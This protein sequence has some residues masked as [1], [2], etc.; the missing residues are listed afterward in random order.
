MIT[1]KLNPGRSRQEQARAIVALHL[2]VLVE[3]W[4]F[5]PCRLP[6]CDRVATIDQ[7]CYRHWHLQVELSLEGMFAQTI[8]N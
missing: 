8:E 1:K 7:L 2:P 6:G 3:A 5:Y 4:P